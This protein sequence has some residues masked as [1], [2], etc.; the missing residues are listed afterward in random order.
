MPQLWTPATVQRS[1][2]LAVVFEP[3]RGQNP[4]GPY[5][6]AEP[7][8]L[9][10]KLALGC[11]LV[12]PHEWGV[13]DGEDQVWRDQLF[14][15]CLARQLDVLIK[16]QRRMDLTVAFSALLVPPIDQLTASVAAVTTF[17][18]HDWPIPTEN[19]VKTGRQL[20]DPLT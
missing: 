14:S 3:G 2:A 10:S 20:P 1:R 17:R 16:V 18:D 7:P 11:W 12:Y 19:A 5:T 4:Y 8:E 6:V 15:A 9:P 13:E